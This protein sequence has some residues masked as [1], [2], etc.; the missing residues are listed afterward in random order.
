MTVDECANAVLQEFGGLI[1]ETICSFEDS[2]REF[3]STR[4][5]EIQKLGIAESNK[6]VTSARLD[7]SS[8]T[9]L[10][11]MPDDMGDADIFPAAVE[12]QPENTTARQKVVIVEVDDIPNFEGSRAIAFYDSPVKY[13]LAWNSWDDGDLYLFYDPIDDLTT[14]SGTDTLKF[15]L[16]FRTYLFKKTAFNLLDLIRLKLA[17][18]DREEEKEQAV[19]IDAALKMLE[20]KL[21]NQVSEW[22]REFRRWINKDLSQGPYLRRTQ[23]E[24]NARAYRDTSDGAF[25]LFE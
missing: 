12:Y 18:L 2:K 21:A 13:R 8:R 5:L 14:I 11:L 24:I 7:V 17:W 1:P 4:A 15:P 23:M 16:A 3:L 10:L 19:K 9:G 22:A 20:M 6:T 25:S